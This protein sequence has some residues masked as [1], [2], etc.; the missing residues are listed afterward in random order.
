MKKK[1][2][3]KKIKI[4]VNNYQIGNYAF[5]GTSEEFEKWIVAFKTEMDKLISPVPKLKKQTNK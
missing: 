5:T 3:A 1:I 2:K 4:K